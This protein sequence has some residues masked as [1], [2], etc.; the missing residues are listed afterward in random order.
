MKCH[1][2][3]YLQFATQIKAFLTSQKHSLNT[4]GSFGSKTYFFSKQQPNIQNFLSD[5]GHLPITPIILWGQ[6]I[7]PGHLRLFSNVSNLY[8]EKARFFHCDF[9]VLNV[10]DIRQTIAFF[11]SFLNILVVAVVWFVLWLKCLACECQLRLKSNSR[12]WWKPTRSPRS[13]RQ[14]S[15]HEKPQSRHQAWSGREQLLQS[16]RLHQRCCPRTAF[17]WSRP[18]TV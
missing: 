18:T 15:V 2:C 10:N 4:H 14:V 6:W 12:F 5:R 1:R 7:F 17:S 8:I 9:N 11:D 3:E 16:R 13:S